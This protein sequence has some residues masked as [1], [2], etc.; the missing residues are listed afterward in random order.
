LDVAF[1]RDC[2]SGLFAPGAVINYVFYCILSMKNFY[3]HLY[4]KVNI[5]IDKWKTPVLKIDIE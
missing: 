2:T 4:E 3:C 1:N 5:G